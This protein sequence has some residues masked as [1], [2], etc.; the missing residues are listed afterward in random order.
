MNNWI[1]PK[2][3]MSLYEVL[4]KYGFAVDP[5]EQVGISGKLSYISVR[6]TS[7]EIIGRLILSNVEARK[8]GKPDIVYNP[9]SPKQIEEAIK[10]RCVLQIQGLE[11]DE[12]P[13]VSQVTQ[14]LR[15]KASELAAP[16]ND[17]ASRLESH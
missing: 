17:L 2:D 13:P 7:S 12:I 3:K 8:F 16:L 14:I 10:L 4:Q 5:L 15:R 9:E 11:F 6:A 1:I